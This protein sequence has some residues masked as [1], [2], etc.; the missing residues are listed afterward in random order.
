MPRGKSATKKVRSKAKKG[1]EGEMNVTETVVKRY[2]KKSKDQ[3]EEHTEDTQPKDMPEA[4][5][6]E[7]REEV[8]DF[9]KSL[10]D[11]FDEE[12][13]DKWHISVDRWTP[14]YTPEGIKLRKRQIKKWPGLYLGLDEITNIIKSENGGGT[15]FIRV[16]DAGNKIRK[17]KRIVIEGS[18]IALPE[19]FKYHKETIGEIPSKD[20]IKREEE[21]DEE[22]RLERERRVYERKLDLERARREFER[23]KRR[24]DRMEEIEVGEEREENEED[25]TDDRSSRYDRPTPEELAEM[26][27][28]ALRHRQQI[29][30]AEQIEHELDLKYENRALKEK[31]SRI[32]ERMEAVQDTV[33]ARPVEKSGKG[34]DIEGFAPIIIEAIKALKPAQ[35]QVDPQVEALKEMVR[36]L[37]NKI[38]RPQTDPIE[39][40]IK[41]AKVMKEDK[42]STGGMKTVFETMLPLITT[43]MQ[44]GNMMLMD[45]LREMNK[46]QAEL[47]RQGV[48]QILEGGKEGEADDW[49]TTALKKGLETVET[50][51][52]EIVG[53]N[54]EKLKIEEKK[55]ELIDKGRI[56]PTGQKQIA[57]SAR[58]QA[59]APKAAPKQPVAQRPVAPTPPAQAKA[60][61]PK[62]PESEVP[63]VSN[64]RVAEIY[65]NA[66][67]L[68]QAAIQAFLKDEDPAEFAKRTLEIGGSDVTEFLMES[69]GI[70][71][72]EGLAKEFGQEAMY[73]KWIASNMLVKTWL[74]KWIDAIKHSYRFE[75]EKPVAP[76]EPVEEIAPVAAKPRK[77]GRMED[78]PVLKRTARKVA[79]KEKPPVA[80]K[81]KAGVK[82]KSGKI[83]EKIEGEKTT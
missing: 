3:E 68:L 23:E 22:E 57:A 79:K 27:E 63:G 53:F 42:D 76:E 33:K 43:Q 61:A 25:E 65:T 83:L 45:S 24:L 62:A 11:E 51:G 59:A 31:L 6:E 32:E 77:R 49:K 70:D 69:E 46:T 8:P 26:Q 54:K 7:T 38:D 14:E 34:F 72:I 13:F 56:V 17:K 81:K 28:R 58:R 10:F 2:R 15:Y 50:F 80:V 73:Q 71:A 44:Q 35:P 47:T 60:E 66:N 18:P 29:R 30:S 78:K 39:A 12:Q 41:V 64:E 37:A 48:M 19:D 82:K 74:G 5:P 67:N 20:V 40:M 36:D 52:K 9:V 16:C 21:R 4:E 55:L 1:E 75:G